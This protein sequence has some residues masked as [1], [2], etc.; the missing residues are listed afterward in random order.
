MQNEKNAHTTKKANKLEMRIKLENST[1]QTDKDER[2]EIRF[3]RAPSAYLLL[4]LALPSVPK[5]ANFRQR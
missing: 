1:G 3:L 2:F 5:P 4:S